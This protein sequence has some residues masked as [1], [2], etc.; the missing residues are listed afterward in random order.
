MGKGSSCLG[1]EHASHRIYGTRR[2]KVQVW[3][4]WELHPQRV[5]NRQSR[6]EA[7]KLK[8]LP[9]WLFLYFL[10]FPPLYI[11]YGQWD[12]I[13]VIETS[14]LF[15]INYYCNNKLLALI[16]KSHWVIVLREREREIHNFN[17]REHSKSCLR[18]F[19]EVFH[20]GNSTKGIPR[21]E[22]HERDYMKGILKCP[23]RSTRTR[24]LHK[25]IMQ[26]AI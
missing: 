4:S 24:S 7:T 11:P 21:S 1:E 10:V 2:G 14:V 23:F 16:L 8:D 13:I 3:E 15:L 9:D 25:G 22:C 18:E 17:E 6:V 20:K 26:R 19:H 5:R 12:F